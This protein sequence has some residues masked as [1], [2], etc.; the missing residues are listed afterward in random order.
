MEEL[1]R[2][3]KRAVL[4]GPYVKFSKMRRDM[5]K[6]LGKELP[7]LDIFRYLYRSV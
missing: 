1:W 4:S 5:K 3:M 6:W 2:Q 7:S